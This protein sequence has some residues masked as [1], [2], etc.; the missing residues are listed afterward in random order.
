MNRLVLGNLL[1]RPLRS[2]ISI[3]AVAI[4]VAMILSIVGIMT[5]QLEGSRRSNSGTTGRDRWC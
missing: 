2:G 1:H 3:L 5:G 4:E